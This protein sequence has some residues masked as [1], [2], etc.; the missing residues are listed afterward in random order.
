MESFIFTNLVSMYGEI[1]Y[2]SSKSINI[3]WVPLSI[4]FLF[5][6]SVILWFNCSD[7]RSIPLPVHLSTCTHF[8][9]SR[10]TVWI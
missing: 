4:P 2:N 3:K 7:I 10:E 8:R 6:K 1:T 5:S 9:L